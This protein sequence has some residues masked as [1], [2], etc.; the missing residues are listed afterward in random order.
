MLQLSPAAA[1]RLEELRRA[2]DVPSDYGIRVSGATGEDGRLD[3][4]INFAEQPVEGD[5]VIEQHGARVFVAHDVAESLSVAQIDV[6]PD[7][8]GNGST[9]QLILRA[10]LRRAP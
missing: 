8:F 3:L 6:S 10:Q 2:R 9:P 1:V 4:Q 5:A 7:S